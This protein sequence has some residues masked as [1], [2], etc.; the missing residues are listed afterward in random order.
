MLIDLDWS[1]F[2][3]FMTVFIQM[4]CFRPNESR[5]LLLKKLNVSR[6]LLRT[7]IKWYFFHLEN[8]PSIIYDS[9]GGEQADGLFNLEINRLFSFMI[10]LHT[11]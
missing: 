4:W 1:F 6:H 11:K 3:F 9:A 10:H 7:E 5:I 2:I 8:M